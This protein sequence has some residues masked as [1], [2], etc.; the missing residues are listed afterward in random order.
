MATI[1]TNKYNNTTGYVHKIFY[2][3]I[4][5][6]LFQIGQFDHPEERFPGFEYRN[7]FIPNL[8]NPHS[9]TLSNMIN[10]CCKTRIR[11]LHGRI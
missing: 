6:L 7:P 11:L 3:G 9:I 4:F 8:L 10:R 2:F 1:T 5:D